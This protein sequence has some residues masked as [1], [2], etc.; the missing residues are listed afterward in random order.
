MNSSILL[1]NQMIIS[2]WTPSILSACIS[3]TYLYPIIQYEAKLYSDTF[4]TDVNNQNSLYMDN[5]YI[6]VFIIQRLFTDTSF[7][8]IN[9][10][11]S[12]IRLLTLTRT[13]CRIPSKGWGDIH[14]PL[15]YQLEMK[16]KTKYLLG[17]LFEILLYYIY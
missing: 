7:Q 17:P 9:S 1:Y 14:G 5:W 12:D 2:R 4:I 6:H 11:S 16:I 15:I 10:V 8:S 13:E 3:V